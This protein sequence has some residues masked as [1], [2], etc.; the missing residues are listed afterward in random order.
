MILRRGRRIY[1]AV[2]SR[3]SIPNIFWSISIVLGHR[4]LGCLRALG[5]DAHI[6]FIRME[7]HVLPDLTLLLVELAR[8]G[9]PR[10]RSCTAFRSAFICRMSTFSS[11]RVWT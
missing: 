1:D 4:V 6:S 2:P 7:L 11:S 9:I 10:R 8:W 3:F 5:D